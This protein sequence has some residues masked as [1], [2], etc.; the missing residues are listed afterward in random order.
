MKAKKLI[1]ILLAVLTLVSSVSVAAF[2]AESAVESGED[3][4]E[5]YTN[6]YSTQKAKVDTMTKMFENDSFKMYFDKKSGEFAIENKA[7]GEY[8]FSN[9]YDLNEKSSVSVN[10]AKNALLSQVLIEYKDVM[11]GTPAYLSS[12]GS[13]ATE[14]QLGFKTLTNG[15]RVEYALG[16]VESKRLIPIMIEATRFET[17]IDHLQQN[18]DRRILQKIRPDDGQRHRDRNH[19]RRLLLP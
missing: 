18:V 4:Y 12:F 7:T 9:P 8:V 13:A 3:F 15:V 19:A 2:A 11:T 1:C 16:T 14:E 6:T 17:L 10:L 5:Y